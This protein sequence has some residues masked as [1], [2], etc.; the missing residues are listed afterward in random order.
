M[1][2][3]VAT[4][5][6]TRMELIRLRRR[7]ELA[8]KGH[9][10]LEQKMDA[11]MMEFLGL[12]RRIRAERKE[13]FGKLLE[14]HRKLLRCMAWMGTAETV[15]ASLETTRELELEVSSRS[16][17]GVRV[18]MVEE[19]RAR[20]RPTERGYSLH[21]GSALLDEAA[22][23]FEEALSALCRLAEMEEAVRRIGWELERTRR[24]VNAL[25]YV[26]LPRLKSM[27]A[28]IAF[29]LDEMERD[30][31]ARLKRI[32]AMLEEREWRR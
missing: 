28:F 13:A 15:Q 16:I 5:S 20:R 22:L 11:L 21:T 6:P 17:M 3:A 30:N 9:D 4:V 2:K 27:V 19:V 1:T 26:L 8:Q 31:F 10:L 14:A 18:P 24:R 25:E 32:K 12:A 29:R 7:I 23:Q